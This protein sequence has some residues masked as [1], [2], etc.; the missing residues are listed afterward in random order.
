MSTKS[1]PG[2]GTYTKGAKGL[3]YGESLR[4]A[5]TVARDVVRS[6]QALAQK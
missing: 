4:G 5:V 2:D 6:L 3:P 1:K